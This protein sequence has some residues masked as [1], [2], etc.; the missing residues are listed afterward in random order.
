M[1]AVMAAFQIMPLRLALSGFSSTGL[2]TVMGKPGDALFHS[3]L[4]LLQGQAGSMSEGIGTRRPA[5][6]AGACEQQG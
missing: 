3:L 2:I 1:L 4:L 5:D 6:C